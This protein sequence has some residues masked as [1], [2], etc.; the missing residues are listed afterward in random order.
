MAKPETDIPD[1]PP[2][3]GEAG[4]LLKFKQLFSRIVSFY[5][6][7]LNLLGK[8]LRAIGQLSVKFTYTLV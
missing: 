5:K 8:C 6:Y 3:V 1:I 2:C 7:N 4:A